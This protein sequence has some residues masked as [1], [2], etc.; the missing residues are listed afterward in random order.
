MVYIPNK[1][2]LTNSNNSSGAEDRALWESVKKSNELAFSALFKK[3]VN[4]LYN[5]GMHFF[6]DSDLVKDCIQE[7]FGSIWIKRESLSEVVQVKF[8]L[9]KSFRNLL[10]AK[11]SASKKSVHPNFWEEECGDVDESIEA[12]WIH[13]EEA[14]HNSKLLQQAIKHLTRRQREAVILRFYNS[15]ENKQIAEMMSISV[16]SVHNLLSKAISILRS[17]I[18]K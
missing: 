4:P 11:I 16:E 10:F 6:S 12:T 1:I 7:L 8:Y 5:Y 3:F 15:L 13:E 2:F 17:Q 9:Y 14:V 18:H